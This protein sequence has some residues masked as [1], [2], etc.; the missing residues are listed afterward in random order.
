MISIS[1]LSQPFSRVLLASNQS[2]VSK[3]SKI[4]EE[5]LPVNLLN[6][7]DNM[8]KQA[9]N[10]KPYDKKPYKMVLEKDKVYLWCLCGY[11]KSQPL[12]DGTHKEKG[13]SKFIKEKP[14]KVKVAETKE[15]WL[16]NCKQ[17]KHRP[18]CDGTHRDEDIQAKFPN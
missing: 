12:C 9:T 8:T 2:Q 15:Y 6:D 5:L 18:F 14:I 7:Y 10:G 11:S 3:Y 13:W 17:T 4:R 16:C 1:R